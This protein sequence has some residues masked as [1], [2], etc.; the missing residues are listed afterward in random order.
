MVHLMR[1]PD[2]A[3]YTSQGAWGRPEHCLPPET[4]EGWHMRHMCLA[5]NM[6]SFA[7]DGCLGMG[8][9]LQGERARDRKFKVQK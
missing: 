8:C 4:Q 1:D 7:P 5:D 3:T 9:K 2:C 6:H